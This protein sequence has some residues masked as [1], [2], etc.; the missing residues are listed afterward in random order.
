[1]L[2]WRLKVVGDL[3]LLNDQAVRGCYA[4]HSLSTCL[5]MAIR[6]YLSAIPSP[7][8]QFGIPWEDYILE[9]FGPP[10]RWRK[11]IGSE[12]RDE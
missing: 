10:G 6:C 5:G 8:I 11:V 7:M 1:M 3:F 2:S 12:R 4:S 9:A